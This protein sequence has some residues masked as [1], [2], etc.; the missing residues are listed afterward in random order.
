MPTTVRLLYIGISAFIVAALAEMVDEKDRIFTPKIIDITTYEWGVYV[1][2]ACNG[3]S[4][5]FRVW[6]GFRK[7][8]S[9]FHQPYKK[10]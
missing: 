3:K 8:K 4:I 9:L 2:L 6:R 1:G 7:D 10:V 5:V